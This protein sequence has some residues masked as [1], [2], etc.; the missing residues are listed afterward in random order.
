MTAAGVALPAPILKSTVVQY[1]FDSAELYWPRNYLVLSEAPPLIRGEIT[2]AC[3]ADNTDRQPFGLQ[4]PI[5]L[6]FVFF[7][8]FSVEIR[9]VDPID[10]RKKTFGITSP[11]FTLKAL[12]VSITTPG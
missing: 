12:L 9:L 11:S 5:I 10:K 8:L 6:D 3:T 4:S 1:G 2:E 7:F